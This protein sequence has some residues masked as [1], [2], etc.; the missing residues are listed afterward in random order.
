MGWSFPWAS[1]FDSDF[2]YDFQAAHTK[3]QQQ[4]GVGKYNF[5]AM[6]MRPEL[7]AGEENPWVSALASRVGTLWATYRRELPGVSAFALHDEYDSE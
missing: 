3:E 4:S 2:N 5:R 7:E 1:S 6:D